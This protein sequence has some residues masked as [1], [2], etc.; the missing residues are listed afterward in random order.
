MNIEQEL[1]TILKEQFGI[2]TDMLNNE[3]QFGEEIELDGL[4]L[5][6]LRLAITKHFKIA[7][8]DSDADSIN[9]LAE[10][11]EFITERVSKNIGAVV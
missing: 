8:L 1:K 2:D 4:Q 7:I 9:T 3:S 6:K 10:L 11:V 5:L